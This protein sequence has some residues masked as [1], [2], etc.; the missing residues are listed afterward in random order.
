M[1][2]RR[3][4]LSLPVL[5]PFGALVALRCEHHFAYERVMGT[6]LDLSVW[7]A[8]PAAAERIHQAV[9]G[10]IDRLCAI[11]STRDPA[12]EISGA[13]ARRSMA[14][15]SHELDELL[16]T[17][18]EWEQRTAGVISSRPNGADLNV[19]ALG[20]AYIID[21]ALAT[22]SRAVPHAGLLLNVGGDIAVRGGP[23]A[24]RIAN[25][26][27]PHDNGEPLT[28]IALTDGAVA[29]SGVYARGGH[30][31]DPR[32]GRAVSRV[33]G[34]TVVA[35]DCL[36]ANA[37]AT[38]LCIIAPEDG[39]ALVDA[40][41]GAASLVVDRSGVEYRSA[42]FA[43][44]ERPRPLRTAAASNWPSSYELT[45]SL[46]V[47]GATGFRA[48]RPYVAV[49][50]EDSNGRL[51]R[52][53]AVWGDRS[54]YLPELATF[55]GRVGRDMNLLRSVTR[56]TRPAGHYELVWNGLDDNGRAVPM[57][58]YKIS[59]ETNQQHGSYAR[60]TGTIV[61]GGVP[62]RAQLRGTQNFEAVDIRY[63]LRSAS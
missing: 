19:D 23:L 42:G 8:D 21:R 22:G 34:A 3:S 53:L 50:I 33:A 47:T 57:G 10:E 59:V 27:A 36:A 11:L 5:A 41:R 60:Q 54:R 13:V 29:T 16:S 18:D 15:R 28:R 24:V 9:L 63:G 46:T 30:I 55:W 38:A 20:K 2:S 58:S 39:R 35:G 40:T 31:R 62:A 51:V 26:L 25:P 12:S 52:V 43:A 56:A 6:S 45:L 61:C 4:F 32:S 48:R 37:L 49:W 44:I 17:Y 7:R 14:S 1:W